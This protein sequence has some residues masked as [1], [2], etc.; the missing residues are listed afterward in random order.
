MMVA[1]KHGDAAADADE[2]RRLDGEERVCC[3]GHRVAS[4][5]LQ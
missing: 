4:A 5:A 1:H 3:R 2:L